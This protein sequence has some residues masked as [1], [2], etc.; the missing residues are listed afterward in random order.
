M[1]KGGQESLVSDNSKPTASRRRLIITKQRIDMRRHML[2]MTGILRSQ[3][4]KALRR[5]ES[6]LRP[7]RHLMDMN[8]V[9]QQTDMRTL[10]TI[11]LVTTKCYVE[12]AMYELC[13]PIRV[14]S[15][16]VDILEGPRC[17]MICES[18]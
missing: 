3:V 2:E 9:M 1:R 17:R 11:M 16:P 13:P 8:V 10:D 6:T 15:L 12:R 5:C 7:G 14:W 18:M 4:F